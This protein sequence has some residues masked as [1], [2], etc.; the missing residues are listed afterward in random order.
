MSVDTGGLGLECVATGGL[1]LECVAT[2]GLG[3]D[4]E[5]ASE[6]EGEAGRGFRMPAAR[7]EISG[8]LFTLDNTPLRSRT[9]L[10]TSLW[11]ISGDLT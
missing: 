10:E 3:L 11:A 1:G 2:G 5:A 4:G 8:G 7:A 6:L 9:G